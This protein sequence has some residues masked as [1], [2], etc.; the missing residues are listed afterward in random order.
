MQTF[1]I[2]G[3]GADENVCIRIHD[4]GIGISRDRIESIFDLYTQLDGSARPPAGGIGLGLTLVRNLA[5]IHGGEVEAASEG[6][7]K[8]SQFTVRLPLIPRSSMKL[9]KQAA[10][11]TSRRI[12]VV[13]DN[14]DIAESLKIILGRDGHAVSVALDVE[15]ELEML[16]TFNP[17]IV[18]LDITLPC[19]EPF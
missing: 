19:L 8:G 9:P 3:Q 18:F 15:F 11:Q 14:G 12:L 4:N 10:R 13:E 17:G 16:W 5:E 1:S 7:G 2:A 6:L